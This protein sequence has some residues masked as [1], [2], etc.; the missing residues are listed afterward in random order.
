MAQRPNDPAQAQKTAPTAEDASA[1]LLKKGTIIKD[2]WRIVEFAGEGGAGAVY[3]AEHR[4]LGQHVAV[5]TLFGKFLRDKEMRRRFLEEAIIQANLNHPNIARVTDVIDDGSLCAIIMEYIDGSSLDKALAKLGKPMSIE[6]CCRLMLALLDGMSYAHA[7]GV[8]H[9]DI[10]PANI[11]LA[12]TSDGVQPKITDFGIAKVLSDHRRTETG[13]AMGTVYYASPEQL[14]DAKSVDHRADIYSLG[15]TFYELLT[16]K[17]PFE[18]SSMYG[19]M[20]L[21][22]QGPRP[23]PRERRPEIPDALAQVVMRA[24]AI[25]P[26]DRPATCAEF[27]EEVRR[28]MGTESLT[29]HVIRLPSGAT[30]AATRRPT[31]LAGA[32]LSTNTQIQG[33]NATGRSTPLSTG[34][35]P[36]PVRTIEPE[37]RFT[38]PARP[39]T[40]ARPERQRNPVA[41]AMWVLI[42]GVAIAV[43]AL[44]VAHLRTPDAPEGPPPLAEAAPRTAEA[45]APPPAADVPAEAAADERAATGVAADEPEDEAV[46]L[47]LQGCEALVE[48]LLPLHTTGAT[49]RGARARELELGEAQCPGIYADA[50]GESVYDALNGELNADVL[51]YHLRL[52]R[53]DAAERAQGDGCTEA[54]TA[55]TAAERALRRIR[56]SERNAALHLSEVRMLQGRAPAFQS[57]HHA[58]VRRFP[59]C[60]FAPLPIDLGGSP[61][62]DEA[63]GSGRAP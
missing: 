35:V 47:T 21:H 7:Q 27:A 26:S 2:S 61:Q 57:M 32:P 44:V 12:S 63:E 55:A 53:A 51:R 58:V 16:Q 11:L 8:V 23:D 50:A 18:D 39:R 49:P 5:K 48:A 15:C 10:K 43:A 45:P 38:G 13:T 20:R 28:A 56:D 29:S 62:V 37:L 25:A 19:V 59:L 36:G 6:A 33:A 46:A 17:L 52:V 42:G 30:Q 14:T 41:V 31:G 54:L 34:A 22:V 4:S 9:R 3:I 60:P 24:M 40:L 1:G